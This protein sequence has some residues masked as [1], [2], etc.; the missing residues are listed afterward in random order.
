MVT[1]AAIFSASGIVVELIGFSI[2]ARELIRTNRDVVTYARSLAGTKTTAQTITMFSGPGGQI[3]FDGG[4]LG[5]VSPAADKLA[6][7]VEAGVKATWL[8]LGLTGV[9]VVGQLIGTMMA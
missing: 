7:Q 1:Y 9:G 4:S 3:E 5:G 6:K 2:L 8:G